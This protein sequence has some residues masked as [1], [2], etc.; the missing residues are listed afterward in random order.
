MQFIDLTTRNKLI[1]D[2]INTRIQKVMEHGQ[3]ILGP[4]VQELEKTWQSTQVQSIA[5]AFQVEQILFLSLLWHS[6]LGQGMR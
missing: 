3:Y 4:E 2:K 5:L 1:G 6:V